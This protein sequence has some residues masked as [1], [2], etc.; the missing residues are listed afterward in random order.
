MSPREDK[1]VTVKPV[2]HKKEV[3]TGVAAAVV[4]GSMFSKFN[5]DDYVSK[6]SR[7]PQQATTRPRDADGNYVMVF[8]AG[9]SADQDLTHDSRRKKPAKAAKAPAP[10]PKKVKQISAEKAGAAVRVPES[11]LDS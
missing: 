2:K 11:F 10:A 8:D 1:W 7:A 9:F 3:A 5:D 4:T 6:E